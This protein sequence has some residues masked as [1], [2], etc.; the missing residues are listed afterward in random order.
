MKS[1]KQKLVAGLLGILVPY[2]IHSFYLGFTQKGVIQLILSFCCGV[3][4]IWSFVE[5]IILLVNG[6]VDSE[7]R[8][9]I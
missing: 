3:G 2:G 5:G 8:E 7:G 6:G 9:L 1:D 4:V